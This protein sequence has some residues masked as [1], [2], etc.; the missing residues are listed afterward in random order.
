MT[1][2]DHAASH[3]VWPEVVDAMLPWLSFCGN[4]SSVHSAGQ[5]AQGALEDAR[6]EIAQFLGRPRSGIVFTSGATESNHLWWYGVRKLGRRQ[7]GVDPTSH[8]CVLAAAERFAQQGGSVDYLA[9]NSDGSVVAELAPGTDL[10]SV[11][12]VNH[13]TGVVQPIAHLTDQAERIGAWL[14]V[15]AC[16]S[17]GRMKISLARPHG[18]VMSAHKIGG[19][20]GIGVLSL[21][22]GDPFPALISGGGQERG[23]RSG[24]TPVALAVGMAEACRQTRRTSTTTS[25]Q[26][27]EADSYLVAGLEAL[28]GR[29]VGSVGGRAP[30]VLMTIFAGVA[31]DALVQALDLS[32]F[33]ASAGAA[34]AS[35]SVGDSP[36][37]KSMGEAHPDSGL[38]FSFDGRVTKLEM[39]T[40]L[41][42]LKAALSRYDSLRDPQGA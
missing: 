13:E 24:T 10:I 37:L 9:L 18:V 42:S 26:C 17:L 27:A 35:G 34:C 25:S 4:P 8:P 23:R 28:G 21:L 5:T 3:P 32:G 39:D 40:L 31:S 36:V 33:H 41:A 19:P 15:D 22:D 2:F 16:Q 6:E 20:V 1:Y 12:S 11:T 7:A 38:R 30:G 14:H 29:V